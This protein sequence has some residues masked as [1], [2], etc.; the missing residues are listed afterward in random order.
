MIIHSL[1][2]S[3]NPLLIRSTFQT[4][5]YEWQGIFYDKFQSLIHQVY[6]SNVPVLSFA[7]PSP[8]KFQSLINQVYLSNR[9]H[10]KPFQEEGLR[11]HFRKA[12]LFEKDR[13]TI[14]A[15]IPP[16]LHSFN[17]SFALSINIFP[18]VKFLRNAPFLG[19][20]AFLFSVCGPASQ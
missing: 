17:L 9:G 12:P 16:I 19:F 18:K 6:L 20:A 2:S 13:G 8:K 7:V 11:C 10:F 15:K 3:F 14:L 5:G 1:L 4:A